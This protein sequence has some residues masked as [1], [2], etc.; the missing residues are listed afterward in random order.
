MGH[1]V[2][3]T[4][5]VLMLAGVLSIFLVDVPLGMTEENGTL[6]VS[7]PGSGIRVDPKALDRLVRKA[8]NLGPGTLVYQNRPRS[9][10]LPEPNGVS[11]E[12]LVEGRDRH[13]VH[14]ALAVRRGSVTEEMFYFDVRPGS[15]HRKLQRVFPGGGV[16]VRE[17]LDD[18]GVQ[19]GDTVRIQAVGNGFVII[20]AGI[21]QE[22]GR[23]GDRV[24]VFNPMSGVRFQGRVIGP[25]RVRIRVGGMGHGT[26]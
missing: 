14:M 26:D 9:F 3:V 17:S 5:I 19:S 22:S 20:L 25:D 11:G 12:I 2:I 23:S 1:K 18:G 15:G 21:A 13:V 24:T 4:R 10:S 7:G 8:L 16:P 6:L